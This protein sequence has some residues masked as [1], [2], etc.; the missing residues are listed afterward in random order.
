MAS[1][2][3]MVINKSGFDPADVVQR[4]ESFTYSLVKGVVPRC[5][6]YQALVKRG[7][8]TEKWKLSKLLGTSDKKFMETIT[9]CYKETSLELLKLYQ[10]KLKCVSVTDGGLE[11]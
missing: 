6:F 3:D 9:N 4:P 1:I 2:M 11:V 8:V 10:D 5:L 7:L